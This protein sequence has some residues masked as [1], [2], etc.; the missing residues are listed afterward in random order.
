MLVARA[1]FM[2]GFMREPC[3]NI[4]PVPSPFFSHG[5]YTT[6]QKRGHKSPDA[7]PLPFVLSSVEGRA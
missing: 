4:R 3:V 5:E 1:V 2:P 6:A 7:P